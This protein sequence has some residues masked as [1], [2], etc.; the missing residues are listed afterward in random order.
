M[1]KRG[2]IIGAVG[3]TVLCAISAVCIYYLNIM[4]VGTIQTALFV[5]GLCILAFLGYFGCFMNYEISFKASLIGFLSAIAVLSFYAIAKKYDLLYIFTDE[6]TFKEFISRY[7]AYA[8]AVF[9]GVQFL[10]VTVLPL[11][12]TITTLAGIALF[13]V[14]K[15]VLYSSIG[16]IAGSML[17]FY[18][19][20][21]F[22]IKLIVWMCGA[23]MFRKY[24]TLL[25]GKDTVLLYA[26]FLLP[27]FPDDLLCLLAGLGTMSYKSFF[28]MM[29]I[30]RPVGAL[31]VAGVF[32][33][34]VSIP[35]SGWGIAVWIVVFAVCALVFWALFVYGDRLTKLLSEFSHKISLK[36]AKSSN[37]QTKKS[38]RFE[39]KGLDVEQSVKTKCETNKRLTDYK[40]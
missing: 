39:Q 12:S 37:I 33:G 22:G 29:L 3:I 18:L 26:M 34:A 1:T 20:R 6:Q 8:V 28:V 16:I 38:S 40:N 25:K 9:I 27:F 13:G 17:A 11:P 23:R 2:R 31:W 7:D 10:Q 36:F 14:A 35:F 21:T 4:N 15:T 5:S 30:A 32:K 24:R 19:G